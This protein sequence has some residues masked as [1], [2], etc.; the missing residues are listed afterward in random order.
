M[1]WGSPD[2]VPETDWQGCI[3]EFAGIVHGTLIVQGEIQ[4]FVITVR[5]FVW[6]Q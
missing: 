5:E 4:D 2:L 1:S 6:M 3:K